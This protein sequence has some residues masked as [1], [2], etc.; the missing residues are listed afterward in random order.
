M[1]K[2][3][4][5]QGTNGDA[6]VDLWQRCGLTRPWNNPAHD[7]EFCLLSTDAELVLLHQSAQLVGTVMVGHDGHRGWVYYLAVDPDFQGQGVG[8]RLIEH[9]E[10]SAR[11]QGLDRVELYTNAK[12]I[13]NLALYP[14][15]GYRQFDR[16]I[17]DGFDRVYF[18]KSV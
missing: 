1:S 18:S 6:V 17:E 7:I 14:R 16:R 8:Y 3:T 2:L 4:F 10:H 15:L 11:Q 12:M 9:V 5:Y 13:E